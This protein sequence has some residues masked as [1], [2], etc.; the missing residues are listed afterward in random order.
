MLGQAEQSVSGK[1]CVCVCDFSS[2]D[3]LMWSQS[4]SQGSLHLSSGWPRVMGPVIA[5]VQSKH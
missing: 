3:S 5:L 4:Y 2:G 1:V